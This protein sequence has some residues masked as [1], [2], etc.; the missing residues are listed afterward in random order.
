MFRISLLATVFFFTACKTE[1]KETNTVIEQ[2]K[3]T[4]SIIHSEQ[5]PV[6]IIDKSELVVVENGT[7]KEYYSTKK[8]VKFEGPQDKDGKRNGKWRYFS[9]S[10]IELSM[11]VYKHGEKHGY[12]IVKYPNGNLHYTGEYSNNKPIGIWKTYSIEGE[13]ITELDYNKL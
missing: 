11:T 2:V 5:E 7:Y 10:G 12:T 8:S 4:T 3:N 6:P 13:M 9:E 1:S